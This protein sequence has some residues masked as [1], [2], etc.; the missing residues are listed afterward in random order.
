MQPPPEMQGK[1]GDGNWLQAWCVCVR[2][3]DGDGVSVCARMDAYMFI[4][5]SACVV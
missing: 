4:Y 2:V 3:D 1:C 5:V